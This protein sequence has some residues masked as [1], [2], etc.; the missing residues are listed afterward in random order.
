MK[1]K[2]GS[3]IK[4]VFLGAILLIVGVACF[5]MQMMDYKEISKP[6]PD[7]NEMSE[8][9]LTVDGFVEGTANATLDYY[10]EETETVAGFI[11]VGQSRWYLVPFGQEEEVRYIGVKVGSKQ[12]DEYEQM[13]AD[14]WKY[15]EGDTDTLSYSTDIIG[16]VSTLDS[17][18]RQFLDEY[19]AA[20]AEVQGRTEIDQIFVPYFIDY[21]SKKEIWIFAGVSLLFAVG[22][23]FLIISTIRSA[24]RRSRQVIPNGS[25]QP[26]QTPP[27]QSY[28]SST[29]EWNGNGYNS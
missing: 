12:F 4:D 5:V 17:E 6:L 24:A 10:C 28:A 2:K 27:E 7:I 9:D 8:S 22:G 25:G 18:E 19:A 29:G 1:Q 11:K 20:V 15:L 14:T 3:V 26:F 16:K 21:T 23:L 13:C